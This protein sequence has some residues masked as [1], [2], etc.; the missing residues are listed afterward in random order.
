MKVLHLCLSCFYIDGFAYQENELIRVHVEAG[1][2]VLVVASTETF[3]ESAQLTY[4]EP[5]T[6]IGGEGARVTRLPYRKWIPAPLARKV[7]SYVGLRA[8]LN[9]EKPDVIMFH[10]L[11]AWDLRVLARYAADNPQVIVNVDSHEDAWNSATSTASAAFHKW[12]YGPIARR[13]VSQTGRALCV[14]LETIHFVQQTYGLRD[15]Q[16][17]FYPL[18]GRTYSDDEYE[19][20]RN[21]T[22]REYGL[23][24]DQ[25]V[26]VQSGKM[27]GPKRLIETLNALASIDESNVQL[28]LAGSLLGDIAEAA[29]ALIDNDRRVRFVGWTEQEELRRLLCAADVYLQ[30]GTQSATM[31]MSLCARCP[32]LLDDVPSHHPFLEGNGWSINSP[33]DIGPALREIVDSPE[34]L[35]AMSARSAEIAA[36]LLDYRMLGERALRRSKDQPA[37]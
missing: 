37:T 14:S 29:S 1:H 35:P 19:R 11:A 9:R 6:Y 26:L 12:F 16:V 31:Q 34:M 4:L 33:T 36:D 27:S 25:V 18:G 28:I 15:D 17:E 21:E 20:V 3:D 30:P 7:R 24:D 5:S 23:P 8:L 32:V 10:G 13:V 2:D 22:R